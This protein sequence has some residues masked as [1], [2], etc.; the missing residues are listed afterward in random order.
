MLKSAWRSVLTLLLPFLSACGYYTYARWFQPRPLPE[1]LIQASGRIEGDHLIVAGK[2]AGKVLE[3]LAKEGD[4][5]GASQTLA[6]M[7][8]NQ[9]RAKLDQARAAVMAAEAQVR[10]ARVALGTLEQEVPLGVE[11][12]A[13]DVDHAKA[14]VAKAETA[15]DQSRRD[16]KRYY[17]LA[18]R[19]TIE[20]QKEE[21]ADLALAVAQDD[22]T[23]AR[24]AETQAI[25]RLAQAKLGTERVRAKQ[26]EIAALVA[27]RD[28]A[29]A[30]QNEAEGVLNDLTIKAPAAGVVTAR[31]VE[32]G[33]VVSAGSPLF[34]LVDLDRLYL[35]CYIPEVLIGKVRI[36]LRARIY[37]DAFPDRPFEATV[38]N[39]ASR[40]EFTPKEVQTIDERVRLVYA[41]KLYLDAN[42]EHRHSP[43][44]PA[45][46]I[47][48]WK[49]EAPW[50]RPRW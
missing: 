25:K 31:V 28:Q 11:V 49:D 35:K 36:G 43:G 33:E 22:L 48:R 50:T 27:Q 21:Q 4:E 41:V 20:R 32:V 37:T 39:V 47:I 46:A 7:E 24:A 10:A 3:L 1:G 19:G 8:D 26:E 5:V 40:A 34:D 30:A 9:V 18:E 16:R 13:A 23:V 14:V 15:L 6:R 12:A 45:D 2:Y 29:L 42:P 38:R 17:A 44:L